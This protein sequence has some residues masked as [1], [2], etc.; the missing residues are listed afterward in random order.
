MMPVGAAIM[1]F[2]SVQLKCVALC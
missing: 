1:W 2:M